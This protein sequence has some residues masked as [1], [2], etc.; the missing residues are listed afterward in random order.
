MEV[1][2]YGGDRLTKAFTRCCDM[3]LFSQ[4]R[5][6]TPDCRLLKGPIPESSCS[7][8]S[9][10]QLK[11]EVGSVTGGS[12]AA[13]HEGAFKS[14]LPLHSSGNLAVVGCMKIITGLR[15]DYLSSME[16]KCDSLHAAHKKISITTKLCITQSVGRSF[17]H[18]GRFE[19]HSVLTGGQSW[20][21]A[22]FPEVSGR[23]S[24]MLH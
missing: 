14:P 24:T 19:G 1:I 20:C 17:L 23:R 5:H 15:E 22:L 13:C 16:H 21:Q 3:F 8:N 7:L 2:I 18:N 9:S 12:R 4:E 6:H 11:W 10:Q